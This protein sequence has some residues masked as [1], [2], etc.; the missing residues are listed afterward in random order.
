MIERI[1]T[2]HNPLTII[3]IFAAL[4]EVAGTV[5]LATVEPSLQNVFIWFVMGFP[6][7]LVITFFITLNFNIRV[8]YAPSDF[9]DEENF[10]RIIIGSKKLSTSLDVVERQIIAMQSKLSGEMAGDK[11]RQGAEVERLAENVT[12]HIKELR[13]QVEEVRHSAEVL[14]SDATSE[15]MQ[16]SG[17]QSRIIKYL[18][19]RKNAM[20][21]V[22][23][24]A[25]LGLNAA[26]ITCAL[27]DLEKRG[28]VRRTG[29][30]DAEWEFA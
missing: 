7:L 3:A 28:L 21:P 1:N 15:I 4:A 12:S 13:N 24:G 14:A 8:L 9:K 10:I 16:L 22:D 25:A 30:K 6:T 2:I 29:E 26:A 23:I 11:G 18:W 20:T 27:E 5:S 19:L 17:L